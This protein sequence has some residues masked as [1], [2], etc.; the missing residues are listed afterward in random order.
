MDGFIRLCAAAPELK[1]ADCRYNR[2]QIEQL[3]TNASGRN[4]AVVVFPELS[5][6]G[7]TCGDLF[8]TTVLLREAEVELAQ[9]LKNTA[10]LPVLGVVGVPVARGSAVYDCAAVF[11]MGKLLAL[12]AKH[13]LPDNGRIFSPAPAGVRSVTYA[14]QTVPLGTDFVF[15]CEN[16]PGLSLAVAS[17]D[18]SSISFCL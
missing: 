1:V 14:G 12:C 6:T 4:A 7:S 17:L 3:L 5:L 15:D 13:E 9:L 10:D 18:A 11:F 8:S 2:A 16:I